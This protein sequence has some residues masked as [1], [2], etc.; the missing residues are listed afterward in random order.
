MNASNIGNRNL[1]G[2]EADIIF[3]K[4]TGHRQM[5][6]LN[7]KNLPFN[8]GVKSPFIGPQNHLYKNQSNFV[9]ANGKLEFESWL[10]AIEQ[11]AERVYP[12]LE[13]EQAVQALLENHIL[14]LDQL[15]CGSQHEQRTTGGQPLK[16]LVELLRDQE[17]VQFLSLV[18]KSM[19]VYF[20]HYA[21]SKGLM[22]F[23]RFTKFCKDFSIFPDILP[24]SRIMTFFYTL[25]AI[26]S[27]A[28]QNES[29]SK[30]AISI[31]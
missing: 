22:N 14:R 16:L 4:L 18:H 13:L 27:T 10:V 8:K 21:D 5:V 19:L 17:M 15:I 12:E 31:F 7:E 9:V 28:E 1:Q 26:H 6:E 11:I 2:W 20:V 29:H 23:E 3:S 25:A 30:L 24:K